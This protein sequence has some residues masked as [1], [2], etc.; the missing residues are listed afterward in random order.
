M[1]LFYDLPG[2]LLFPRRQSWEQRK[3]AKAM[4]FTIAFSPAFGL[5]VAEVIRLAYDHKK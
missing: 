4:V 2:R 5:V 3:H 1:Q